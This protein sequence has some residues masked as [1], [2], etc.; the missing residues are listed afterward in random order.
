MAQIEALNLLVFQVVSWWLN[1]IMNVVEIRVVRLPEM[2]QMA[3]AARRESA[4]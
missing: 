1:G 2:T 3:R 4:S